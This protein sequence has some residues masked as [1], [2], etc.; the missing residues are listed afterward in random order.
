MIHVVNFTVNVKCSIVHLL[1]HLC[2]N[3]IVSSTCIEWFCNEKLVKVFALVCKIWKDINIFCNMAKTGKTITTNNQCM[4]WKITENCIRRRKLGLLFDTILSKDCISIPTI[5]RM[6][7]R[8]VY[9][10]NKLFLWY[11]IQWMMCGSHRYND[12]N[13]EHVFVENRAAVPREIFV[14]GNLEVFTNWSFCHLVPMETAN[15]II[16]DIIVMLYCNLIQKEG[17]NCNYMY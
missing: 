5:N 16:A 7:I 4:Y 13:M 11:W 17:S 8:I 2:V 12:T 15:S 14:Y 9:C 1:I 3:V 6:L 10:S